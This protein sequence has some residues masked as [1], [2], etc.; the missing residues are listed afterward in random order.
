MNFLKDPRTNWKYILIIVVLT[1]VVGG[2]ILGYWRWIGEK[3]IQIPEVEIKVSEAEKPEE[4]PEEIISDSRRLL[5][6]EKWEE[7]S[8]YT[9]ELGKEFNTDPPNT[10]V[11]YSNPIKGISLR[12]P[13]NPKWGTEKYK[14][15]PYYQYEDW[16]SFGPMFIFEAGSFPRACSISFSLVRSA[17]EVMSE[18]EKEAETSTPLDGVQKETIAQEI[19]NDIPVVKYILADSLTGD[20][21]YVEVIGKKYNYRFSC[22]WIPGVSEM[23]FLEDTVKTIQ[24]VE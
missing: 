6:K 22:F 24:F 11:L 7:T 14:I 4:K 2:G 21:P 5:D 16:I 8:Y 20:T 1:A 12:V 18:V 17:E 23:E 19:I 10:T 13:Y 15:P 3:E 9:E